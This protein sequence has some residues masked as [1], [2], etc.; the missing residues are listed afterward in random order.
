MTSVLLT[1]GGGFAGHHFLAH[2]LRGT[3]WEVLAVRSPGNA[4]YD[5]VW[6][7]RGEH[8]E[9]ADRVRSV[10]CDLRLGSRDA[11]CRLGSCDASSCG[12]VD[13]VVAY[14][15]NADVSESVAHPARFIT[16]N[17]G[18]ALTVMELA[19][20]LKPRAVIW[21]SS[22]DV[23][24]PVATSDPFGHPEWAVPLPSS[25]YAASKA[26][27]EAVV[28]GYWRTYGVPVVIV[29]CMGIFGER[30]DPS[31]LIP[32]IIRKTLAGEEVSLYGS[33]GQA[34]TRHYIH[35]R[36]LADGILHVLRGRVPA[37]HSSQ[38]DEYGSLHDCRGRVHFSDRPDMFNITGPQRIDNLTLAGLV[39]DGAGM[40]LR[41]RMTGYGSARPG[42]DPDY[43]LSPDKLMSQGGWRPP[44]P[45]A[46]SLR[47][48][49]E[50]TVQ[51]PEWLNRE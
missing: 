1:G 32:T 19:R 44:V 33:P 25:P 2:V 51:H 49:V 29:R 5:R 13:Y 34:S 42:H 39:A 21:I 8:P 48:T 22:G 36:N 46:E 10:T 38:A 7:L 17:T 18:I 28:H 9:W 14:A 23:C 16:D 20:E 27:Q 11:S 47:R 12:D 4:P 3:D 43:G 24:G 6:E 31:K 15:S 30:Q 50:W 45:F 40:P 35:A 41:Y 26:A 37:M